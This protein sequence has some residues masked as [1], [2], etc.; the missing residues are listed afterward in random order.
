MIEKAQEALRINRV[1]QELRHERGLPVIELY[2]DTRE[3]YEEIVDPSITLLCKNFP[4][5]CP[6]R[7]PMS[8]NH[9]PR[10]AACAARPR[11]LMSGLLT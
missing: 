11:H 8:S 5:K 9:R 10:L 6:P 4:V 1:A 7:F 2:P 3:E